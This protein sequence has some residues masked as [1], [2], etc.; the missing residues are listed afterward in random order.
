MEEK[1]KAYQEQLESQLQELSAKIELVKAKAQ[2]AEA[3]AKIQYYDQ[4]EDLRIKEKAARTKLSTLGR[5]G[6]DSWEHVKEGVEAAMD[7]LRECV[8]NS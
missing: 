8:A 5:A 6:A 4:L 2:E 7:D 1:Q 3:R